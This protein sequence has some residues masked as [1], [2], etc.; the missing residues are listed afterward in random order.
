M[1]ENPDSAVFDLWHVH[2]LST[3]CSPIIDDFSI[4]F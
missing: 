3:V 2:T 4:G 1:K